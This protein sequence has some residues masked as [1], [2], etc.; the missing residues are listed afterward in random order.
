MSIKAKFLVGT[1]VA[2]IVTFSLS[3]AR[4]NE[5]WP[6]ELRGDSEAVPAGVLPPPGV[7]G[8]L[9][10]YWWSSSNYTGNGTKEPG[11]S[12]TAL[13]ETPELLWVPGIKILGASYAVAIALPFDY[14]SYEPF[15]NPNLQHA[16]AGNLGIFNPVIFPALLSWS[17]PNNFF[18]KV[19]EGFELPWAT[20]N[21]SDL[22]DG[23]Q[24]NGGAPS[25][26]GYAS[27]VQNVGV[28]WLHGGWNLS[29]NLFFNFPLGSNYTSHPTI[30]WQKAY[31]ISTYN[32]RTAAQY[33][34]EYAVTKTIGRYIFGAGVAQQ[35]QF[36]K[37]TL[38][39]RKVPNSDARNIGLG[40]IFGYQFPGGINVT[41]VWN[42]SWAWSD[43]GGD[44]VDVKFFTK[45]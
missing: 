32:Y 18:V 39:G 45:F 26:N 6:E 21:M 10:N 31:G 44:F 37:D 20:N 30:Y 12:L 15:Q 43:I 3:A 40:P 41:V 22:I 9:D 42:H 13:V 28:S 35:F 27:F 11:T 36:S 34:A 4:A 24:G 33:N 38:N 7:Y 16:G 19:G 1:L 8:I 14:S 23:S 29:A 5:L 2:S 17:L 25:A